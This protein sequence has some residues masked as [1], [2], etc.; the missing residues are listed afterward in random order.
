MFDV[1]NVV[2]QASY[3][4]FGLA[5]DV[6]VYTLFMF[7]DK[8]LSLRNWSTPITYYHV[9]LLGFVYSVIWQFGDGSLVQMLLGFTGGIFITLLL[10]ESICNGIGKSPF[11]SLTDFVDNKFNRGKVRFINPI[12]LALSWDA[13]LSGFGIFA[14]VKDYP[15]T[16]LIVGFLI[17][18]LTIFVF[19]TAA[20][21]FARLLNRRGF[22]S[23]RKLAGFALLGK[24]MQCSVI[25]SFGVSAY[26][27]GLTAYTKDTIIQDSI[28]LLI[29]ASLTT[30]IMWVLRKPL[31]LHEQRMAEQAI[32]EKRTS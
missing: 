6:C 19:T 11:F 1:M 12:I 16:E 20:L 31:W 10:Y 27:L 32:T 4:G 13:A 26:W 22:H 9:L 29:A 21:M 5:V 2:E 24:W 8:S 17:I 28:S 7:H 30:I 15:R 18:G 23:A 25:G 3:I 14:Q